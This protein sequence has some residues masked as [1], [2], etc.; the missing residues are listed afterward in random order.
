VGRFLHSVETKTTVIDKKGNVLSGQSYWQEYL[1]KLDRL[2]IENG[3]GQDCTQPYI[4]S[5]CAPI[6]L[7][8]KTTQSPVFTNKITNHKTSIGLKYVSFY[9]EAG[10]FSL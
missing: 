3:N 8:D 9:S 5:L 1:Q 4:P 10:V 7:L 2:T 6:T